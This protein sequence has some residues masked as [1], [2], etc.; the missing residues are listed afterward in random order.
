MISGYLEYHIVSSNCVGQPSRRDAYVKA[1][2]SKPPPAP[3]SAWATLSLCWAAELVATLC[4]DSASFSCAV[5]VAA[6]FDSLA[7]VKYSGRCAGLWMEELRLLLLNRMLG[8]RR[9]SRRQ[10]RFW[11][12]CAA[13]FKDGQRSGRRAQQHHVRFR[14]WLVNVTRICIPSRRVW[15]EVH[16]PKRISARHVGGFGLPRPHVVISSFMHSATWRPSFLFCTRCPS[17]A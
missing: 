3:A 11:I 13:A 1:M 15:A 5:L 10:W 17:R 6:I 2:D 12:V 7:L 16:P 9:R 4:V 8:I 14:S